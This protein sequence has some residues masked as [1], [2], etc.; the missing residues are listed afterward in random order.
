MKKLLALTVAG[1]LAVNLGSIAS[2]AQVASSDLN[3]DFDNTAL[4]QCAAQAFCPQSGR[5]VSCTVYADTF[6]GQ[7]C[8]YEAQ[9]G[10]G[11]RCRG[12]DLAGNW[13]VYQD[14]CIY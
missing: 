3:Q 6:R 5:T 8:T 1:I 11:V 2:M 9:F 10:Y 4:T 7:T 13:V 14:Y 12:W